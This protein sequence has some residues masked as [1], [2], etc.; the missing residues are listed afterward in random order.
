[1]FRVNRKLAFVVALA[2]AL[3]MLFMLSSVAFAG[4]D[5]TKVI[6]VDGYVD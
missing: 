5:T 2:A 6:C 1:M 3:I 4:S